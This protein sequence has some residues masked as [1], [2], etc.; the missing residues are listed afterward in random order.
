V[1]LPGIALLLG[2]VTVLMAPI[3]EARITRIVID[4][5]LS[6]SPVFEGRIF[7]P[8]GKVGPYE[9]L[10]GRAVGEVDPDDP[11]N[12]VITDL[13][14][15]PRNARGNVEYSMDI[16]ILKPIDLNKGNHKLLLDFNNRGEMRVAALNDAALNNDPSKAIHAGTG[17]IMNLGYSIV[18]NGWDFGAT[19]DDAGMTISVPVAKHPD[20]SSITGP[21]YEYINFDDAGSVRYELT[22][23]AATLDKSQATLTVRARLD[24]RP[25]DVLATG[26][27]YVDERTIRL[28]PA[29]TPF[30]QS[31]VYEFTYT[32]KDPV[33]AA[34]GLAATRDLV[35]FLRLAANDEDGNPNPLAGD[36]R[37]TFSFSIS[38]PSRALNDFQALGFNEDEQGRRVIDGMLKWTGGGSGDQINYRFAQ[39]GRTERNR[40][41]HL[42]PEG[43]FPFA[44]PV[45]TDHLSGRTGGR[46]ARCSVSNTCPK[47]IDA[48]SSNEYWVKAGSLLHTDTRGNDLPDPENVRFYLISGLSHSVGNVTSRGQCQQSLN[49]TSPYPAL[50]AL[51]I[52]L[53]QWVVVGTAPPP[54]Q[55]PRRADKTAV[56]AVPRPGHQTGVVPQEDLGWPTIPEVTYTGVITTR[57]HLDF[58]PMLDRGIISHYPPP[59]AGRVAYPHFVSKVDQ[60]GNE[61]AGIRLPPVEA[62]IATTTGWALRRAEFGAND[63][64]EA[65]GQ[66]IVF[67]TTRAERLAAGDPRLSVEERYRDHDGYVA[68]VTRAAGKLEEQRLLLPADVQRYIDQARASG[69]LR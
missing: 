53:D 19:K 45:L 13:K 40:Q 66:H 23:P 15:A 42:Y 25:T 69:V 64:C 24:D 49:P 63:G 7:G 36:V 54:S 27:E 28:L 17:F 38:Q 3:A 6:E 31:H 52:A 1:R 59:I 8:D 48:N 41:N 51:L 37:H 16:F 20:G 50:R 43:V 30:K 60:D 47:N 55:V 5:A 2:A 33:V 18:G 65:S 44:Y 62:P 26:W 14:L 58:G 39:T 68:A 9:K 29:G 61:V 67:K 34:L 32:A 11:R 35:S 57:Y 46:I 10:R 21:S 22:Y 4:P 12:A 56:M